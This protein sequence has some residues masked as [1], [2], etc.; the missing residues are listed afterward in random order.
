MTRGTPLFRLVKVN[1]DQR[2][3]FVTASLWETFDNE[4]IY[5]GNLTML[6]ESF[7]ILQ[8]LL[9]R[10]RR[11]SG[12]GIEYR[13]DGWIALRDGGFTLKEWILNSEGE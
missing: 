12:V 5:C 7:A 4:W 8:S 3:A 13:N 11:G 2:G 9:E 10:G 6:P 1:T